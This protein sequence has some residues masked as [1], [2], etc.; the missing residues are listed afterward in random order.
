MKIN[1]LKISLYKIFH[2]EYWNS[3]FFYIPN[4]PYAFYLIFKA[5]NLV[6]F[7]AANPGIKSSGNGSESK[8]ET[9]QLIPEE[10]KPKS[11]LHKRGENFEKTIKNILEKN[12]LFP[13]IAKPDVGFRGLLVKKIE[14]EID[15]KKYI[16]NFDVDFIIQEFIDYKNECGIFYSRNPKEKNGLIS[17]IT[18]KKFLSVIGDGTSTIQELV[19]LDKRANLYKEL[20]FESHQENL[21]LI[22]EKNK[23]IQLSVIGNHCKGTQ[24]INGN[25]LITHKLTAAFD[26]LNGKIPGWFYGRIDIKYDTFSALE[27]GKNFKILEINGIISEPTH[28]YDAQSSTYFEALKSIRTHWK[29]L[30][31]ISMANHK[32]YKIPYKNSLLYWKEIKELKLYSKKIALLNQ[33]K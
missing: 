16:Q 8:F 20:I 1:L 32:I 12:I 31:E 24:F 9:L 29:I 30:F 6:F 4:I 18:L 28:I 23:E 14:T 10:L 22:L 33:I 2:W 13:V 27:N 25:H 15:L 19:K 7:S 17:S 3:W 26:E 5:K 11:I 21:N